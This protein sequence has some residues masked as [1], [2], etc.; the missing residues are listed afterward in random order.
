MKAVSLTTA[1]NS[2]CAKLRNRCV[3][4]KATNQYKQLLT[5]SQTSV[6]IRTNLLT[7]IVLCYSYSL[8]TFVPSRVWLAH[9]ESVRRFER[10]STRCLLDPTTRALKRHTFHATV[11]LQYICF[12]CYQNFWC[13]LSRV[14]GTMA[15][16]F[17]YIRWI[18]LCYRAIPWHAHFIYLYVTD[19]VNTIAIK[20]AST[21]TKSCS[22]KLGMFGTYNVY[23]LQA[24][25]KEPKS[26]NCKISVT[27]YIQWWSESNV[28]VACKTAA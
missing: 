22:W 26:A 21:L 2:V 17:A 6:G 10:I 12:Q 11:L 1:R 25:K 13:V 16:K 7:E 5:T 9:R 14:R 23:E 24:K 27:M 8:Y 19:A 18:S 15:M 3:S 4:L 20:R 28:T